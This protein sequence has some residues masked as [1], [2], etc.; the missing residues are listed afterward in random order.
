M[1][2]SRASAAAFVLVKLGHRNITFVASLTTI[3]DIALING[4]SSKT[5]RSQRN[6]LHILT[7]NT[8]KG[9][10]I[11]IILIYGPNQDPPKPVL[12]G[13]V[14][15]SF[16]GDSVV[17]RYPV[18]STFA[19]GYIVDSCILV[20]PWIGIILRKDVLDLAIRKNARSCGAWALRSRTLPLA[21][22]F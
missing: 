15:F 11:L 12:I 6:W 19:I 1:I 4:K 17:E 8:L 18:G 9:V 22:R 14:N 16:E 5:I 10:V 20:I 2:L 13:K 7:S 21:T 3:G